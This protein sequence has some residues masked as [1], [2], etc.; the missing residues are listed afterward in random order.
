MLDRFLGFSLRVPEFELTGPVLLGLVVAALL[1]W[2]AFARL[3]ARVGLSP[4]LS[5]LMLLP[6][7]NLIALLGLA[8]GSWPISREV[9]ALR[10]VQRA[11]ERYPGRA[12]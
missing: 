11:A 1:A 12:A 4:Y 9:S 3:F 10:R 8:F 5:V 6:G 7:V 2:L